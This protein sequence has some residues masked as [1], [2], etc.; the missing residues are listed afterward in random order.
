[1][2][3]S[4]KQWLL[5]GKLLLLSH[6]MPWCALFTAVK[7]YN[8]SSARFQR[9]RPNVQEQDQDFMI[10]DQDFHFCLQGAST[11]RPWS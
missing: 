11:P 1:M 5:N 4:Q 8:K 2:E 9:P 10:E 7:N 3:H 6:K